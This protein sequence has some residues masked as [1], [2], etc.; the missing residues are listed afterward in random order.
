MAVA[1]LVSGAGTAVA[2]AAVPAAGP[3][4]GA[5]PQLSWA[6]CGT[7]EDGTA[8]GVQCAS[9]AV[10]LDHDEPDGEV[11]QIALARVPATDAA[12]RIGSLFVNPGGPGGEFVTS[13]QEAGAGRFAALNARFDIVAFAPRGVAPSTPAIDCRVDPETGGPVVMPT[14]T[15]FDVDLDVLVA[16]AQSYVDACL[17]NNGEILEHLSTAN[18]ARDL[19]LLRAAVGDDRLTYLGYSYGTLIGATYAS[20]F[21]EGYRA[22]VLDAAVDAEGYLNDPLS[23]TAEQ[24]AGI[25]VALARFAEACA[26]DQVAC[27]GFGGTDPYLAYDQ[28]LAAAQARP[29]PAD[30][31]PGDPRPVS[32]DDIR[33]V[34]IRLLYAKQL[35]GL[36]GLVLSEAAQGDA[37]FIRALLDQVFRADNTSADRQFAI[38]ASEMRYP[39]DDLQVYLDRG[40]ESWA[41]FPHFGG[42]S[43]YTEIHYALWP[44][45]DE[46]A[47]TGP[48]EASGSAPAPLVIGTTYDPATPYAWAERLTDDLGT[49]R[50]LTMEGDGHAAYGGESACIDSTTEAYLV[51]GAL[52]A[53]GT[54]CRQ[55][56]VFEAPRPVPTSAAAA[57]QALSG[58]LLP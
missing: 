37:S 28:L 14:P 4:P 34:T 41:S 35:W 32:A 42:N 25:E 2:G 54:V 5:V 17:A 31:Y 33:G 58:L 23:M 13:L 19:D 52:P 30:A 49:A 50:L 12:N 6:A 43:G 39:R 51:G 36:L 38:G 10:P 56:T 9:A 1:T 46:D 44:V 24:A 22:L 27:S 21:P 26:V 57:T 29:I 55:E 40:A 7:T 18:V 11:V 45:H 48:F 16:K 20:L 8:A 47:F 3:L 53:P 15:P